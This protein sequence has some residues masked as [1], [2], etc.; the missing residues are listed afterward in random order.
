MPKELKNITNNVMEQIRH[1]KL[2]M[3]PKLYFILGSIFTIIGLAAS[4]I[5]SIFFISLTRF[6]F[7]THGPMGQYR[8]EQLLSSFPWWAPILA[9]VGLIIGLWFLRQLNFSY[10]KNPWLII[11]GFICVI[12]IT[13]LIID[14]TG[15][16]NLWLRH[17]PMQ[18]IMRQYFQ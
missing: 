7:K 13:S 8:L 16:D 9:M 2:K 14:V 5:I 11:I 17:G 6:A 12:L 10:K 15:L 4:T 18:G 1:N 3:R